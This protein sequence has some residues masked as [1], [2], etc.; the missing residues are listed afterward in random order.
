MNLGPPA[1]KSSA[2]PIRLQ[3]PYINIMKNSWYKTLVYIFMAQLVTANPK[4]FSKSTD[5]EL[6]ES[7]VKVSG[8]SK[9]TRLDVREQWNKTSTLEGN[10]E[11][12][13]K[14]SESQ[15]VIISHIN[16]SKNNWEAKIW[17]P[18][19]FWHT[20]QYAHKWIWTQLMRFALIH[21]T[22]R[23]CRKGK[24]DGWWIYLIK[25]RFLKVKIMYQFRWS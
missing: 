21:F 5:Q 3:S 19:A 9:F 16:L 13:K 11:F 18:H 1:L 17:R 14:W 25:C 23:K 24:V 12:L 20:L 10:S 6:S 8:N 15:T 4:L 22:I 2:L 7:V